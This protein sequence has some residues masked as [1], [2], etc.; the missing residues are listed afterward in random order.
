MQAL[1]VHILSALPGTTDHCILVQV[2]Q[3]RQRKYLRPLTPKTPGLVA[4]DLSLSLSNPDEPLRNPPSGET[5][6][7]SGQHAGI[8]HEWG[9]RGG[10]GEPTEPRTI[11]VMIHVHASAGRTVTR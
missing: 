6:P 10:V 9:E 2:H 4:V 3:A 11:L 7:H 1:A 8:S 5:D